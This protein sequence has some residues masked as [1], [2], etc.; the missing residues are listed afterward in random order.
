MARR[1]KSDARQRAEAYA[2]RDGVALSAEWQGTVFVVDADTPFGKR[3]NGSGT[4]MLSSSA[5]TEEACWQ[6]IAETL[7]YGVDDCEEEKCGYCGEEKKI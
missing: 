7:S 3:F 4:H 5:W 2:K 1:L 6:D